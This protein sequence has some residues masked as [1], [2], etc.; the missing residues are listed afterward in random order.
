[1]L[2]FLIILFLISLIFLVKTELVVS[3][4]WLLGF[5]GILLFF[6][7]ILELHEIDIKHLVFIL[8]E[9]LVFKA[10]FIPLFLKW[11]IK[12]QNMMENSRHNVFLLQGFYSVLF[13]I[14]AVLISFTLA[15]I[16]YKEHLNIKYLTVAISSVL[17]GL[18]IAITHKEIITHIVG[19]LVLENGIFLLSLA[20]GSDIPILINSAIL[21][22]IFSSILVMGIFFNRVSITFEADNADSLSDLKD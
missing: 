6:I 1:M 4:V 3:Y 15:H 14:V 22:D 9:T 5:Q 8:L 12:R 11:I 21:L 18:F 16:L 7:G 20:I 2:S 10:I 19:Y 17:I 13:A